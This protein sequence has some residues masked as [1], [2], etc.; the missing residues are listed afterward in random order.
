MGP[1]YRAARATQSRLSEG[2]IARHDPRP[3]GDEPSMD[4]R[5]MTL[6]C[7]LST[8]LA[9]SGCLPERPTARS[10]PASEP[11]RVVCAASPTVPRAMPE[12]VVCEP[13]PVATP[14][15]TCPRI[16][17][18]A[19]PAIVTYRSLEEAAR[20]VIIRSPDAGP[21][22][23][24]ASELR[25]ML[26]TQGSALFVSTFRGFLH[27]S[28][29][30]RNDLAA[31]FVEPNHVVVLPSLG[32]E[33]SAMSPCRIA[34][35]ESFEIRVT[36]LPGRDGR[37]IGHFRVVRANVPEPITIAIP[38]PP[39]S[40][41]SSSC[42]EIVRYRI[43]DHFIDLSAGEHRLTL[44]Q[45]FEEAGSAP[46]SPLPGVPFDGYRITQDRIEEG[47]CSWYWDD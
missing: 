24:P 33:V 43:E 26:G 2:A 35:I 13:P 19:K 7:L 27:E 15:P 46:T 40:S 16:S 47:D 30:S 44:T 9:M 10:A 3:V 31:V 32:T 17:V 11:S 21:L 38:G 39:P 6:P 23:S 5:M 1:D 14:L 41:R 4:L 20:R 34:E 8:T 42:S 25:S 36:D 29:S 37:H 22:P 28:V 12:P 45:V 18:E